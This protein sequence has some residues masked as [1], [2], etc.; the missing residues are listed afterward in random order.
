MFGIDD[1][2]AAVSKLADDAISRIW[3]D[4]TEEEKLKAGA[5]KDELTAS[6]Q[7]ILGQ[8]EVNKVEAANTNLFV[9]GWRPATGWVCVLGFGY[10]FIFRPLGNAISLYFGSAPIFPD[11]AVAELST[12]LVGMLGLGTLRTVE[13]VN[14]V[15]SKGK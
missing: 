13:K 8:L 6:L 10:S 14:G 9:S 3:P 11:I 7:T 15:V 12:L 4:A 5:L 2:V 1:A